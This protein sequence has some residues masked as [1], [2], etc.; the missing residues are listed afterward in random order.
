ML[1]QSI[2]DSGGSASNGASAPSGGTGDSFVDSALEAFEALSD[3]PA[4]R[5]RPA[6]PRPKSEEPDNDNGEADA[7]EDFSS[8]PDN[9]NGEGE[10]EVGDEEDEAHDTRGSK[11]DPFSV[12]DLPRDKFIELKIDGEKTVVSLDEMAA[13]YIREQTFSSRIN[14]TKQLADEA[15][16]AVHAAKQMQQRV[17]SEFR[18]FIQDPDQ[19]FEFFTKTEQREQVFEAAAMRYAGLLKRFRENPH[20]RL[21]Y[22][23]QRDVERLNAEREHFESQKRAEYEARTKKA[24]TEAALRVF[25][26]GWEAGLRKAGFPQQ[27]QALWDEVMLRCDQRVRSG[28][29]VSS[30]DV[31]EFV[32][33]AAKLL[34]LPPASKTRPKTT[35]QAASPAP[36]REKKDR[37][38]DMTPSQRRNDPEY[39]LRNLRPRD[40][41]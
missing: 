35:A 3:T 28:H 23:R 4:G 11:E 24:Q 29:Q 37:W 39:F 25:K 16:A 34:E 12:K 27:T 21:A 10:P 9:D 7:E 5:G 17:A 13:G 30:D 40:F 18:E 31:A 33:R 20:E 38:S 6:K 41:R 26:P 19:L 32:A 15:Q 22:E 8:E 2:P 14:K 36:R 1:T